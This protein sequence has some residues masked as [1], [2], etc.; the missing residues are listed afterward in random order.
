MG[1]EGADSRGPGRRRVL[2]A[3]VLA[4]SG[5]LAGLAALAVM[6]WVFV[7]LSWPHTEPPGNPAMGINF[8]CDHAAY[9]L[10]GDAEPSGGGAGP[11]GAPKAAWCASTFGRLLDGT[12]ARYVRLSVQWSD[13]EPAPDRFDFSVIDGLLAEAENRGAKVLLTVGMKAQRHPEYYIPGWVLERA[14]L[15]PGQV[16]SESPYL[17]ERTLLVIAEVVRHLARSPAIDAWQA[18]NEPFLASP[19]A[20]NWTIAPEFVAEEVAAIRENDPRGRPVSINH[21][22]HFVFDRRWKEALAEGDILGVSIYPSRNYE[23]LGRTFVVPI[24]ELGPL[25][26]NY[27]FEAR[28]AHRAGRQFWVTEMQAE[29]WSNGDARQLSP[30]NPSPNLAPGG[31]RRNVD[32]ARRTGADRVYLWGAEWWLLQAERYGDE[33]WMDLGREAMRIGTNAGSLS[34]DQPAPGSAR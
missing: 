2:A 17:R 30:S 25:A 34:V 19:R 9:L 24:L 10:L 12:A 27:A 6:A 31:L 14:G 1:E 32:Y 7:R 21:G 8:S 3:F 28:T 16:V 4:G 20:S 29:P 26:P 22:H 5:S 13:V 23:L 15:S 11:Q 33:R 18:D